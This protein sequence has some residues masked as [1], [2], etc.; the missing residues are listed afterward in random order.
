MSGIFLGDYKMKRLL[1]VCTIILFTTFTLAA[2]D[3]GD[4]LVCEWEIYDT[5]D[6]YGSGDSIAEITFL[7]DGSYKYFDLF[8]GEQINGFWKIGN[9]GALQMENFYG[10]EVY[11]WG[12]TGDNKL[13]LDPIFVTDPYGARKD[14]PDA[15]TLYLLE[16]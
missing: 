15:P 6:L 14:V 1:I 7:A 4:A 5:P 11:Y 13:F 8:S 16:L 9:D 3:N 12:Y 2:Q 10:V